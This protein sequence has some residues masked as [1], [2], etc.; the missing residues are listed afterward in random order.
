M[1]N[2]SENRLNVILAVADVTAINA[3]IATILSK[4]PANTTLT[5][6]QRLS[7]NAINVANKV[8]SDDCLAEAQSNGAGILP[9]FI[10]LVN[11]QNDLTVFNQLDA[12][13]S[14]LSNAI[15]RIEDAKRI[16]GH[17]AY[18]Q[19]INVYNSFKQAHD[20]GIPNATTSFNKLKVR[21]EAQGNVGKKGNDQV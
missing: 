5:D 10:N 11:L 2:L 1:S 15:Q 17:E 4:V 16:A 19:A 7:Y 21:F 18:A 20:S 6:E 13:S 14:A 12:I 8:F 3:S 9:G